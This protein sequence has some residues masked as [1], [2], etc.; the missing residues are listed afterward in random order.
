MA[1]EALVFEV[2]D[3]SYGKYV[4]LNSHKVPVVMAFI[5]S[6]SEHCYVITETF[7]ALAKEYPEDFVFAKLDIDENPEAKEKY[8]IKNVPTFIVFNNGEPARR[9][10]G[11]MTYDEARALLNDFGIFRESDD[12]RVKAREMHM[13]GDTAEAITTLS[14]AIKNDPANTR[15]AL[16][17]VQIFID[18]G[19]LDEA[20]GLLNRLPESDRNGDVGRGLSGQLW[21]FE[22]AEKT[23]GLERLTAR[24]TENHDDFDA[25]FDKFICEL[26]R[27]NI[28]EAMAHLFYIQEQRPDYKEGA[29]RE[30]IV[31]V[32][33]TLSVNS[34]EVAQ[35][36]RRQLS[37]L[38]NE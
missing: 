35:A 7:T 14:D 30:M 12:M 20:N 13:R 28:D 32:I 3:K 23:E 18:I 5:G 29:A 37:N 11:L 31:S 21:V 9:E 19:Q 8:E 10:E 1:K 27:H 6:W 16:D 33:N 26:A 24:I 25:H 36:Y 38:L 17:M 4:M 2:S 15:V 34:P 22:Q